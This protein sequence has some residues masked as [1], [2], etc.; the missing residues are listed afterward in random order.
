MLLH[1]PY[2]GLNRFRNPPQSGI[3]LLALAAARNRTN[4]LPPLALAERA[5]PVADRSYSGARNA[6][7]LKIQTR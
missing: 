7:E 5:I 6:G 4:L 2:Q 1:L 3:P